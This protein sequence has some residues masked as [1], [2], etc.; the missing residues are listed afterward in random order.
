M[1]RPAPDA[2]EHAHRLSLIAAL[3]MTEERISERA[4]QILEAATDLLRERGA[5]RR[6]IEQLEEAERSD[7]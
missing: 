3:R 7:S 6:E 4:T 2:L 1:T 5:L